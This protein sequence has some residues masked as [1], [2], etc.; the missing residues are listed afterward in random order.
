MS[1]P[2]AVRTPSTPACPTRSRC[3]RRVGPRGRGPAGRLGRPR[4][5]R[6]AGD[7][8]PGRAPRVRAARHVRGAVRGDRAH[9]RPVADV[10]KMMASRA[11]RRVRGAVPAQDADTARRRTVADIAASDGDSAEIAEIAGPR[12]GARL[13]WPP[14][15]SHAAGR[16]SRSSS[17][18]TQPTPTPTCR[19]RAA[20][21]PAQGP[22]RP[23][24]R[25]RS[26]S[27][28]SSGTVAAL[29]VRPIAAGRSLPGGVRR[30][31]LGG[32]A[33]NRPASGL[34]AGRC[35]SRLRAGYPTVSRSAMCALRARAPFPAGRQQPRRDGPEPA[36]R[37]A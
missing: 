24:R 29:P 23:A 7:A 4:A 35:G 19:Q 13:S 5:A 20:C 6:G 22:G 14:C 16:R 11:R 32:S 37:P 9:A 8:D 1:A 30:A 3:R 33:R 12:E 21:C 28:S 36:G 25:S 26:G 10:T 27:T 34:L 15:W 18:A 17:Y 2:P 31:D